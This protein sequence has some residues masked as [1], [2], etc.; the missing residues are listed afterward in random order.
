MRGNSQCGGQTTNHLLTAANVWEF[1]YTGS[2]AFSSFPRRCLFW[3]L[4]SKKLSVSTEAES[5]LQVRDLVF[6]AGPAD[7]RRGGWNSKTSTQ[8][9]DC[10]SRGRLGSAGHR[11]KRHPGCGRR[12][13]GPATGTGGWAPGGPA[14]P[15]SR[16]QGRCHRTGGGRT[17]GG[18]PAF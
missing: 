13:G 8:R 15:P 14:R 16:R 1:S 7:G 9:P 11:G 17:G 3:I 10:R 18:G 2:A 12:C 5:F 4:R 6:S